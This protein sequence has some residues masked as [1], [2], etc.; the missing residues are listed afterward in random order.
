MVIWPFS[1]KP[2]VQ[3]V[4]DETGRCVAGACESAL[5]QA[6]DKDFEGA[7]VHSFSD[8]QIRLDSN[9]KRIGDLN[10]AELKRLNKIVQSFDKKA[11]FQNKGRG[12]GFEIPKTSWSGEAEVLRGSEHVFAHQA[13]R[14]AFFEYFKGQTFFQQLKKKSKRGKSLFSKSGVSARK[15]K[16]FIKKQ[17]LK[18]K[19]A[20][21]NPE[22]AEKGY[23]QHQEKKAI[24]QKT[25]I[26][27]D[28][29]VLEKKEQALTKKQSN[30]KANTKKASRIAYKL[31]KIHVEKEELESNK[32]F[33]DEYS[34][35]TISIFM[36]LEKHCEKISIRGS[37]RLEFVIFS[38][39]ELRRF[40]AQKMG[41]VGRATRQL[42]T[43]F[44]WLQNKLH[45]RT[46]AEYQGLGVYKAIYQV[47]GYLE[48]YD[49]SQAWKS[50][51]VKAALGTAAVVATAAVIADPIVGGLV[52]GG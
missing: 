5:D 25:Q 32:S 4:A 47:M 50:T 22:A 21:G 36:T 2:V 8:I 27:K 6:D 16:F 17:N 9:A 20:A 1:S 43:G 40:V 18:A 35:D 28:L 46:G 24:K 45:L 42:K 38:I 39:D 44:Y 14:D 10:Y 29:A 15:L 37:E 41:Y 34:D 12:T 51:A 30:A 48:A 7:I 3:Y 49:N 19:Q 11:K 26:K 33:L 52:A 13:N 23:A 31:E